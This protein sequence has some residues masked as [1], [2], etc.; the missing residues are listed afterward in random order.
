MGHLS[1]SSGATELFLVSLCVLVLAEAPTFPPLLEFTP[2]VACTCVNKVLAELVK[3]SEGSS[4]VK[5][6]AHFGLSHDPHQLQPRTINSVSY[7]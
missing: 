7:G 1:C 4:E 2:G 5:N 3:T 6:C